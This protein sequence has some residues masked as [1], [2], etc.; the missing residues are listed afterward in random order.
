MSHQR[1]RPRP[2]KASDDHEEME[3]MT[4][5][6]TTRRMTAVFAALLVMAVLAVPASAFGASA[7]EVESSRFELGNGPTIDSAPRLPDSDPVPNGSF[8]L[9]QL[10]V[11]N[12]GDE[13]T[14]ESEPVVVE[15]SVPA[16]FRVADAYSE[17][18]FGSFEAWKCSIPDAETARC[19]GPEVVLFGLPLPIEPGMT[20]CQNFGGCRIVVA[21]EAEAATPSGEFHP[22]AT[23]CGGGASTCPTVAAT[24]P[25]APLEVIP[26]DVHVSRV[27]GGA[28]EE[29]GEPATQAASRPYTDSVSFDVNHFQSR[30]GFTLPS[31]EIKDVSNNFPSGEVSNPQGY[32]T[33]TQQQ[34]NFSECPPESQ[35]GTVTLHLLGFQH[36]ESYGPVGFYN[37]EV[38]Y[39]LPGLFGFNVASNVTEVYATL[40]TGGDY[41]LNL[42]VNNVP[43]TL[44]LAGG[45]FT[46]WGVPGDHSHQGERF[47]PGPGADAGCPSSTEADPKPFVTLPTACTGPLQT[48][49]TI[50]GWRGEEASASFLSHDNTLPTPNPIGLD[51][52]NAV[53]FSPTLQARPTTNVA[54]SASGLDVDLHLPVHESCD[55]GPPLSCE[56]A[57]ATL[58][59]TTVNLPQGM[60]V[61]PSSANG[62]D[63]CSEADFGYT[64]TDP[65]G[66]IHTTPSAATCPDASKLGTVEI[67]TPLLEKPMPGSVYLAKPYANPFGSLLALYVSVDDQKTGLVVKLAGKVDIDPATGRLSATFNQNPQL[68]FEDFKLHF[69][70]G[71][72]GAL[73]TPA[74]CGTYQTTSSLT[75]WTYPES[76]PPATPTDAWAVQTAPGGGTCP[77]S[78]AARPNSPDLDAGS[79]SPVAGLSTPTIVNLRRED[80][81][82]E[83]SSVRLTLPPGLTGKLAGI[84][85]CSD[86]ALSSAAHKSG[87]QE[88]TSPS[89]PSASRIGT[90][91]VGAG[92]GP[93][94]YYAKGAGY[95]AGPYKG[96]PLSMAIITPATAGPFDLGT[97]VVR[98]ALYVDRNT[99]Q[100]TAVS[101]EIPH[102]LQGIPLDIRSAKV[103]LDRANFTRNG[104]SC[105]PSAFAGDLVS[106]LHNTASLS[107][108]FQLGECSALGFKPK[109]ALRLIGGTKRGGHPALRASLRMPEGEANIAGASVALPHSE[110]LDQS[111]IGTVCTRVQYAAHECPAASIYG[112]VVATSPLV[113]YPLEGPAILRSSD[114]KLPDLVMSLHGPP[115]QPIEVDAV[116]RIDSVKG[117][118]RASF[119]ATP[120]LPV[121][122]LVLSMA[123]AKKGLLQNSTNI[124]K[125]THKGTAEFEGQNSKLADFEPVLKNSKCAK[126]KPKH[127]HAS[128]HRPAR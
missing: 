44:A 8:A 29:S 11:T 124:C 92:A 71:A 23:V 61:N 80:G 49:L 38:P 13:A 9:Y 90:V 57:E 56:N 111:H 69:F 81:S 2:A 82:Q 109:L 76:G 89:C 5:R 59:D 97:V 125:G 110:F 7:L 115:S 24:A 52:C 42:L 16:G 86:Q 108:R 106:T 116:G 25:D 99:A 27:D 87:R 31:L 15:F 93:A 70:G 75:P 72:G 43:E 65:D 114:H 48:D 119:E 54:D 37:M 1:L 123:G 3:T 91:D 6:K 55:T 36:S 50:T 120:D 28:L 68:P 96:A 113:D 60:V 26:F 53:D 19:E 104:T 66:T 101:D 33:C 121:S 67:D 12:T 21:L 73:R 78:Q 62:L 74:V 83:F 63:G 88:E 79:V 84:S 46:F 41:G 103:I 100:I 94:P 35:I 95:L 51:G 4:T 32:L 105:D 39:G 22:T 102:I 10:T 85:Q 117:G 64:S 40:R 20:A 112:S 17:K 118:V 18:L 45:K 14:S 58:K 107:E 77:T 47:C 30:S 127:H 122:T 98:V 126:A 128:T 34:L